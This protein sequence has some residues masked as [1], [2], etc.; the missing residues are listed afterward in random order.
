MSDTQVLNVSHQEV[1]QILSDVFDFPND[2]Q[3]LWWHSTAPMFAEMLQTANYDVH[4]QY[5]HLGIYKK[6]VIPFLGVYPTNDRD[7]WLSILTRYGTPFELSLNCSDSV[8]RY[9]FE[10][11]TATTGTDLDP[12]NSRA[13]WESLQKL[14]IIQPGI[15]LEYFRHFKRALTVDEDESALLQEHMLAGG[16]IKTQNKL[17]LD[18]KGGDFVVKTYIYP[19]LKA[20]VTGTPIQELIFG[21]VRTLAQK[22]PSIAPSLAMLEEYVE[23]RGPDS[24]A[25]PRLLSCDL[26]DARQSRIK[27]YISEQMVSLSALQDLWTLGGRRHDASTLAGL[28]LIQEL[29]D[30]LQIPSGCRSYPEG[31]LPLGTSPDEL[32]PSMANYTLLP[33]Q[34]VPEPQ[35]YFAVFGMND[36]AVADA[37]TIFFGRHGWSDMAKKYKNSLK[38]YYPDEHHEAVNYL[39]TYISFS[40]RKNKPYLGVYLQSF[41]TGSWPIGESSP[42]S[43]TVSG[44]SSVC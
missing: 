44:V 3:R 9:T 26:V 36:M 4:A 34:P 10:P 33:N 13:I 39:H 19:A 31:Y 38:A 17:A 5:R 6:H 16:D 20:M 7:R 43:L 42:Q 8:V 12:F 27:I 25:C 1:Y 40:Y 32:L 35:V 11:I 14:M 18:L 30:L 2:D 23:S 21:S 29:W 28:A 15:D 22:N 37:L 41:E 24:T